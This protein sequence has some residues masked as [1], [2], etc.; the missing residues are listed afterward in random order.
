VQ[1]GQVL[2]LEAC[3]RIGDRALLGLL[4]H[5]PRLTCFAV[6]D[7]CRVRRLNTH[8]ISTK[9]IGVALHGCLAPQLSWAA[10]TKLHLG[11][12]L[13]SPH[14]LFAGEGCH[15]IP[16]RCALAA[17]VSDEL[18]FALFPEGGGGGG[19]RLTTLHLGGTRI[20]GA[21]PLRRLSGLSVLTLRW[22]ASGDESLQVGRRPVVH[23]FF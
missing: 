17:Q 4:P 13:P 9:T 23:S 2:A 21:A 10:L 20:S 1:C 6:T 5:L 7:C 16:T 12:R 14:T 3:A 18:L 11:R 15:D 22:E 19:D 8:R